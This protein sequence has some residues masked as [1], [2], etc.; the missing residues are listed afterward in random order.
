M[1]LFSLVV[2]FVAAAVKSSAYAS[3][4][5]ADAGCQSP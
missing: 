2:F 1:K 3:D 4:G 5:Q